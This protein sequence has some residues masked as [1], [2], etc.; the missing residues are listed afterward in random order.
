MIVCV[1]GAGDQGKSL[2]GGHATG[3][4]SGFNI[5][6]SKQFDDVQISNT[7]V[8][9]GSHVFYLFNVGSG[10]RITLSWSYRGIGSIIGF[11]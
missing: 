1:V 3:S 4:C 8:A 9:F 7:K 5:V 11:N 6:V 10:R 2:N